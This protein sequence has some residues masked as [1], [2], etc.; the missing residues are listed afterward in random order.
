MT[1][2]TGHNAHTDEYIRHRYAIEAP[3]LEAECDAYFAAQ[4]AQEDLRC[5]EHVHKYL[6]HLHLLECASL[7]KPSRWF[8]GY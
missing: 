5:E 8:P 3:L 1:P 6:I 2:R 4:K 7:G